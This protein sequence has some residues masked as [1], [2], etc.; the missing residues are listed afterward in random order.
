MGARIRLILTLTVSAYKAG[1]LRQQPPSGYPR[2]SQGPSPTNQKTRQPFYHNFLT[3]ANC[4]IESYFIILQ[5]KKVMNFK[6]YF[7]LKK[8]IKLKFK[9]QGYY[10][11]QKVVIK[12]K[13][14]T[15]KL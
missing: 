11:N 10:N 9:M 2:G 7:A 1:V 3:R 6:K 5:I 13:C 15:D 8:I 12:K 4:L 14:S